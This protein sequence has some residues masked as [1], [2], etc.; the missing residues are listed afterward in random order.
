MIKSDKKTAK[1]LLDKFGTLAV[2]I[3]HRSRQFGIEFDR[4][5]LIKSTNF[6]QP[7]SD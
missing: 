2:V 5:K 6:P 1:W 7:T 3:F 4:R